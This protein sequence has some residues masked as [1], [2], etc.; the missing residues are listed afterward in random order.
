MAKIKPSNTFPDGTLIDLD[1]YDWPEG[2]RLSKKEKLYIVWYTFPGSEAYLD[3]TKAAMKA[4]Y[5]IN[6]AYRA[7]WNL[8]RN[9]KIKALVEKITDSC[10]KTSIKEAAQKLI[11]EKIRRAT[12]S[13]DDFYQE[14]EIFNDDNEPRVITAMKPIDELTPEQKKLVE[15][16]EF[17]NTGIPSY[18]LPNKEKEINEI[19]KLNA[20]MN[21]EKSTGDYDVETTV[22]VIK[23]NLATVKTTIH[24]RN[25]QIKNNAAGYIDESETLPDCD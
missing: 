7:K 18:K 15:N 9:P 25:Q 4:G 17:T 13:I 22:D 6:S 23:E 5:N 10:I 11:Q 21:Q 2:E 16:V 20:E 3:P 14:K 12:Y 1:S 24:L 8:E 19:L